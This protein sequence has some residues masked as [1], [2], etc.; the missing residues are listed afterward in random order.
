[1]NGM[2]RDMTQMERRVMNEIG[3]IRNENARQFAMVN[4]NIRRIA[5]APARVIRFGNNNNQQQEASNGN[6]NN[7]N[8]GGNAPVPFISTLSPLPR[9]LH[10]LWNKYEYGIGGWQEACKRV[11]CSR[12]WSGQVQLSSSK[13]CVGLH[14]ST[15]ASWRDCPGCHRLNL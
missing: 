6:N 15:G 11:H 7:G 5:A 14:C 9:T 10:D 1:M 12:A 13:S 8:G 3:A 4:Q 2:R